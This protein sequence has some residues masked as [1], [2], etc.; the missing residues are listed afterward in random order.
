[1]EAVKYE[2]KINEVK[3]TFEQEN[4]KLRSEV[5][6]LNF[7]RKQE[8]H[9]AW[10]AAQKTAGNRLFHVSRRRRFS[11]RFLVR[12]KRGLVGVGK[13]HGETPAAIY[14]FGNN[15]CL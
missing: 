7:E 15:K 8:R 1:M 6:K 2:E 5:R 13:S 9:S 4:E 12:F 11:Q 3:K 14:R 10:I